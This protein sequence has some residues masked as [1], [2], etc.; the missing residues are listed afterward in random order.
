MQPP[1]IEG[2]Q[3]Q[4]LGQAQKQSQRHQLGQGEQPQG[5]GIASWGQAKAPLA[6]V[7]RA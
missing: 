5:G 4:A 7:G 6:G 1:G 3:H 2:G